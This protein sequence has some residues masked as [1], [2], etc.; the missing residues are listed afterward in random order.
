MHHP[1][2]FSTSALPPTVKERLLWKAI[3]NITHW[4]GQQCITYYRTLKGLLLQNLESVLAFEGHNEQKSKL[5]L[6][7]FHTDVETLPY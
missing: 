4:T 7:D 5:M 6:R 1:E 3:C 2:L